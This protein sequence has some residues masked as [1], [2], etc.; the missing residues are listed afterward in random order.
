[1]Y[2]ARRDRQRPSVVAPGHLQRLALLDDER[3]A[4][5]IEVR[6]RVTGEIDAD[7]T[8]ALLRG[9]ELATRRGRRGAHRDDHREHCERGSNDLQRGNQKPA[10]E[11]GWLPRARP[12]P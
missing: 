4:A 10:S 2:G 3:P 8:G 5:E 12:R 9:A 1:A 6:G 11:R 7:G